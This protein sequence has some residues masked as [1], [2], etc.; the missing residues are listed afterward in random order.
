MESV[1]RHLKNRHV[2]FDLHRPM[3]DEE[4]RVATFY[5][6]NMTGM[7]CGY[8]QYRPDATKSYHND[9]N[10]GRYYTYRKQPTLA[11]FGVE[12]LHLTPHV[13]F[14]TEG[15]FDACRVT[16]KGYS[17]LAVLSNNPNSE[18]HNFLGCLNRKVV[19]VC[20]N[21]LAGKELAKFG[22]VAAY[23]TDKD[24]SDSSDRFVDDLIK[25][26]GSKAL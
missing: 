8:Q 12:S 6:Y 7:L 23:T 26:Y 11:L 19:A 15:V 4:N 25:V 20:D 24:L 17:A 5:L 10:L 14:L 3:V 1:A 18:L 22:D 21:D 13:V 2:D 9:P 16:S